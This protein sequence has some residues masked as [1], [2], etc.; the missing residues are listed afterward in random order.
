MYVYILLDAWTLCMNLMNVV[1]N[2]LCF[3]S[4]CVFFYKLNAD[5]VVY[6]TVTGWADVSKPIATV[7]LNNDVQ[8]TSARPSLL[9]A[10]VATGIFS[11]SLLSYHCSD[12]LVPTGHM[13]VAIVT[14][15]PLLQCLMVVVKEK[16]RRE[17]IWTGYTCQNQVMIGVMCPVDYFAT[18][19]NKRVRLKGNPSLI[20]VHVSK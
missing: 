10:T 6:A 19:D 12:T 9:W 16:E 2:R 14:Y 11:R 5:C 18:L 3:V 17:G 8:M 15:G 13:P 20:K 1:I 4:D 7:D